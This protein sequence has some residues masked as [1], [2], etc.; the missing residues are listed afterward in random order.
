VLTSYVLSIANEA[1]LAIPDPALA[2]METGLR[3]FIEG[4]LA[5]PEPFAVADL[6]MRKLGALEALSRYGKAAPELLGSIAIDPNLWPDSAVIDWASI[7]ART[8]SIPE[9]ERRRDEAE[10][11]LRARLNRQGTAMQLSSS[12]RDQMWWLMVSPA[13][14]MVRLELMLL[15]AKLWRSDAPLIMRGALAMQQRGSWQSTITNAWGTLAVEKFAKAFEATPVGGM[16]TGTLAGASRN[17]DW[18]RDPRGGTMQFAWPPAQATLNVTHSGA[19]NPWAQIRTS[20]AIP[21]RAPFSSGYTIT[22]T[23]TPVESTHSGGWKQGDLVRV[24][25]KIQAQTDMTWVV[26]DDPIPAGASQL[27]IGLGHESQ[28]AI[29]NENVN[30]QSYVWP[31]YVERGFESFRAYYDYVPKGTFEIEYTIR[32]N[33]AG[34]F[35]MPPT[36]VEALY[37]PEMLGE[38]PNAPF[39]VAH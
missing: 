36:H 38:L 20:A 37:E 15:D 13:R 27:G 11:I 2:S 39:T 23:L 7:L 6:P 3:K 31:T 30:N 32:L 16:T 29:A 8:P 22:K 34:T 33:Q 35:Q 4:K 17:L 14:N 10:R 28:I 25:L 9:R 18:T 26:V 24:H 19:G 21:L 1:G 12:E 5:R